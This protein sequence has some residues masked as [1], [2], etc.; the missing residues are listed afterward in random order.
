MFRNVLISI[1]SFCAISV[2]AY[3]F[4]ESEEHSTCYISMNMK[5]AP[6]KATDKSGRGV[7]EVTLKDKSGNP[8]PGKE[9]QLNASWGTFLCILTEEAQS[10][11]VNA[12]EQRDCYITDSS[13]KARINLINIQLDSPVKVKASCDCGGYTVFANGTMTVR[14]VKKKK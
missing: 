5:M 12:A 8:L 10:K 14:S 11:G 6:V 4:V 1:I 13:G 3:D 2:F 7:I 9:I